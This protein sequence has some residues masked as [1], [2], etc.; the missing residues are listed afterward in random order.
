MGKRPKLNTSQ[1]DPSGLELDQADSA[2]AVS[3]LPG[4][5]DPAQAGQSAQKRSSGFAF[6]VTVGVGLSLLAVV[7]F[8]WSA[9]WFKRDLMTRWSET[10]LT[11]DNQAGN[12]DPLGE[13]ASVS[14][15]TGLP[16]VPGDQT[17][18]SN[19]PPL[20]PAL[21]GDS[22]AQL[23]E[24]R[25]VAQ[26]LADSMPESLDALEMQARFEFEFGS[27]E[28]AKATW[29]NLLAR[30]SSYAHALVGLADL[31]TLE[32]QQSEA[33]NYLRRAAVANPNDL[34]QDM[35]L[36][37]ALIAA[38]E[39]EE[40]KTVLESVVNK[41]DQRADALIELATVYL[42]LGDMEAARDKF[43]R[44]LSLDANS[45][46]AHQ[47]LMTVFSRLKDQE[48]AEH[49]RAEHQ[50]LRSAG[51]QAPSGGRKTY[52]DLAALRVDI[53]QLYTY[54]ARVYAAGGN[55]KAA[56]LLLLRAARMNELDI[57]SRTNLAWLTSTQGRSFDSLR[58]LIELSAL[59]PSD[60][61]YA[62]EIARLYAQLDQV[63]ETLATLT[64][65]LSENPD[66]AEANDA[67][68]NYYL[69]VVPNDAL[70]IKYALRA[71]KLRPTAE[72]Y[73]LLATIYFEADK[74]AEGITALES[75]VALDADNTQLRQMLALMRSSSS[76]SRSTSSLPSGSQPSPSQTPRPTAGPASNDASAGEARK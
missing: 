18:Q 12:D 61:S 4:Q 70:A 45:V 17:L 37:V 36:G 29:Q 10:Q 2:T 26:H 52:D 6:N 66:N 69:D 68:A 15:A 53:G 47:G 20:D 39:L 56:E 67:L 54:M 9:G 58:W 55:F 28:T 33:V 5:P 44:V 75:A 49:H 43:E 76:D 57:D 62:K 73:S 11:N 72:S 46:R 1:N 40:A 3:A 27:I 32:G 7:G 59:R 50:R 42:Q 38:G 48:K 8:G 31:A 24:G 41:N 64:E 34:T 74:K 16:A 71:V 19:P 63:D 22:T 13:L 25:R 51:N 14:N 30:Q 23:E 65:F 21:A 60:F 35:K